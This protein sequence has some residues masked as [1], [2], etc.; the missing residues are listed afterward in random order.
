VTHDL[1]SVNLYCDRALLLDHGRLLADGATT[2]VTGQYRRM[3][4]AQSEAADAKAEAEAEKAEEGDGPRASGSA[5]WGT[6]QVEITQVRLR[7]ANGVVHTTFATDAPMT[8]EFDFLVNDDSVG[9]FVAG[10][11]FERTDGVELAATHTAQYGF[12]IPCPPR[13]SRG[14][15]RYRIDSLPLL[16][17]AYH[18]SAA[19]YDRH[20]VHAYDHRQ[21]ALSFR[22][23]DELGRIGLIEM[24]GHWSVEV[25]ASATG[26]SP[27]TA[28]AER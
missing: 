14:T 27:D 24:G 2:E 21:R 13:G 7:D 16:A 26:I 28:I 22:V 3:V 6:R 12:P 8:A 1:N 25:E 20:C 9:E 11:T 19:V 5:R 10:W 18:L 4:G 15:V 17:A 23:I